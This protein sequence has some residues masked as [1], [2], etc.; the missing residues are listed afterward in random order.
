MNE[1]VSPIDLVALLPGKDEQATLAALLTERRSELGVREL[2][3]ELLSHPRRDSGC[4]GEAQDVL[5]PFHRKAR[6]A[7]VLFDH[8]GSGQD[9]RAASTVEADVEQRLRVNG[10]GDRALAIVVEPE[11]ESWVWSDCDRVAEELRWDSGGRGLKSWLAKQGSWPEDHAK[12]IN[13]KEAFRLALRARSRQRSPAIYSALA[14][15]LPLGQCRER[16]FGR[17]RSRLVDWF[18]LS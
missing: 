4:F 16:G 15:N 9:A 7:L 11:L 12:P 5:R 13:P 8:Y 18:P 10:W 2:A 3:F 6:H 17:L 14:R 1:E